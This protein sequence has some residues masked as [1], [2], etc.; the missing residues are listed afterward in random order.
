[1]NRCLS[2]TN[3]KKKKKKKKRVH[4]RDRSCISETREKFDEKGREQSIHPFV[5]K[6]IKEKNGK[7]IK[8][9]RQS[10]VM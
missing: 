3:L 4:E 8:R 2:K 9:T 5:K 1:M 10:I 6:K 7:R